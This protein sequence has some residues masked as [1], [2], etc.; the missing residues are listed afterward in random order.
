M[1]RDI[2]VGRQMVME[3]LKCF[4]NESSNNQSNTFN[5]NDYE[6]EV[7]LNIKKFNKSKKAAKMTLKQDMNEQ[8][9]KLQAAK[10]QRKMSKLNK[11]LMSP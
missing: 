10:V 1:Y 4:E 7:K 8:K 5:S 11:Q 3:D 9:I 6:K 2:G